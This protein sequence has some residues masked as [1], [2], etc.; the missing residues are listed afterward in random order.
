[1]IIFNMRTNDL[2][3]YKIR[4]DTTP[5]FT[6]TE[7]IFKLDDNSE[8]VYVSIN[9]A[10]EKKLDLIYI[11]GTSYVYINKSLLNEAKWTLI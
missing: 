7:N 9:N 6:P 11:K 4:T 2:V 5:A 3:N 1:M 8:Y 10:I